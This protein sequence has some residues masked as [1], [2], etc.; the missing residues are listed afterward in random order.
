MMKLK[1][2]RKVWWIVVAAALG[3]LIFSVWVT[4]LICCSPI[5]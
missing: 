2:M 5:Q 3:I 4:T 1:E